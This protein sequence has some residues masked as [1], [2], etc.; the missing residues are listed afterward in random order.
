MANAYQTAGNF[1]EINRTLV[2][3]FNVEKEDTNNPYLFLRKYDLSQKFKDPLNNDYVINA[4]LIYIQKTTGPAVVL[5]A[6]SPTI[7]WH[8]LPANE[9]SITTFTPYIPGK[10]AFNFGAKDALVILYH[11]DSFSQSDVD[12][13]YNRL[14]EIYISMKSRGS[15]FE[16]IYELHPLTGRPRAAGLTI[17][18]RLP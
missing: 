11:E 15:E 7:P 12:N 9:Q 5:S 1:D 13:F 8:K 10:F 2:L 18:K 14:K 16:E 4:I 6:A 3:N 17:I